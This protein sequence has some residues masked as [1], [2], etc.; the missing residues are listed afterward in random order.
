MNKIL[1]CI[2]L[3]VSIFTMNIHAENKSEEKN[4]EDWYIDQ[5]LRFEGN[6]TRNGLFYI[7]KNYESPS[8]SKLYEAT[9]LKV[10]WKNGVGITKSYT[11]NDGTTLEYA[12]GDS[13]YMDEQI[14]SIPKQ[15]V[16]LLK[17]CYAFTIPFETPKY[18]TKEIVKAGTY[19]AERMTIAWV[20]L[21]KEDGTRVWVS[22]T[23]DN[24]YEFIAE[25]DFTFENEIETLD[26][27]QING[28]PINTKYMLNKF[29][30]AV[31][32]GSANVP[33]YITIHNTAN[34]SNGADAL[35]HAKIQY[36]RQNNPD[37]YT[38]WHYQ[39]D[40]HSI[41][42]SIPLDEVAWHA[43]DGIMMGNGNTIAIEI[44]ENNDG[45]YAKAEKNAAYLTAQLLFELGLPK[46]AIRMHKDWS[47]K[48]CPHNILEGTKGTMGWDNF[49]SF[50]ASYYDELVENSKKDE[51]EEI[52]IEENTNKY[53]TQA[54][55]TY[56]QYLFGIEDQTEVNDFIQHL[57]E[58]D[59]NVEA[60]CM[61]SKDESINEGYIGSGYKLK[62]KLNLDETEMKEYV[63]T[64]VILGDT[65]GDGK[66]LPTDYVL[67]KNHIMGKSRLKN[68]YERAADY[69]SNQKILPTDYVKIKNYIMNK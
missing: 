48:I 6:H 46:D 16:T 8:K 17:D 35:A 7:I 31:R 3:I 67:I 37:V 14:V 25:D 41:Y 43:G 27:T 1:L 36:N 69:D 2:C 47:G 52:E 50:V 32:P 64:V 61:N 68:V 21:I 15:K 13:N 44:C 57:N 38:S 54:G 40:D 34:T 19:Y 24:N 45:N 60:I 53:L 18:N 4:N 23:L 22:P 39:V 20:E 5:R 9:K 26:V 59:S 11:L 10:Y 42:Q 56:D 49:K 66:I 30:L 55:L 29:N 51:I 58:I 28:I 65:N 63:F 33:L 12:K 62:I